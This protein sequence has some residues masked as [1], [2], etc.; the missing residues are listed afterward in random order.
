MGEN[1]MIY[2]SKAQGMYTMSFKELKEKVQYV[3]QSQ[4]K[5]I[6]QYAKQHKLSFSGTTQPNDE[7]GPVLHGIDEDTKK[8]YGSFNPFDLNPTSKCSHDHQHHQ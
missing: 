4:C 7:Y 5:V 2:V 3:F 8:L 6:L 1:G